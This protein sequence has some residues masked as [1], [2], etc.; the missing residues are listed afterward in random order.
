MRDF[1]A[2]EEFMV[3]D[4]PIPLLLFGG[5]CYFYVKWPDFPFQLV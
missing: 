4:I 1:L 2:A 5:F 3:L